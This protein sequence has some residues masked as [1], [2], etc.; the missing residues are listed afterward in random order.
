M[1]DGGLQDW[2]EAGST[3]TDRPWKEDERHATV[4]MKEPNWDA[5]AP[6]YSILFVLPLAGAVSIVALLGACRSDGDTTGRFNALEVWRLDS[7]PLMTVGDTEADPLFEVTGT[8]ITERHV[9]IA[10]EGSGTLRF[11]DHGGALET[12]VGGRGEGPGEYGDLDWMRRSGDYLFAYDR[13]GREVSRYDLD[14]RL[15]DSFSLRNEGSG[16]SAVGVFSDGSVLVEAWELHWASQPAVE[17]VPVTLHL[18]DEKGGFVRRLLEMAGPETWYE[19]VGTT[20]MRQMSRFF[21][22]ISGGA[23]VDSFFV[24]MENDSYDIPVYG[25]DGV[26]RDTMRPAV[27]PDLTPLTRSEADLSRRFLLDSWDLGTAQAEVEDMLTAMGLPEYLPPYGRLSLGYPKHPPFTVADGL[28]WALRY[29]GLPREGADPEGPEWYVF[30]PGEGQ[31]ANLASPDD[32]VLYDVL[33]DLA[34]VLR[35]T[36][37][38]EEIVELRRIVGR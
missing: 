37:L 5:R 19:P 1:D 38:D 7:V 3:S 35:R 15:L 2:S 36:E 28:V 34:A 21:G 26:V 12:E 25:P 22:R 14:G 23:V 32:V 9:V 16:V 13:Y 17:R 18:F 31:I 33:G 27:V 11:Y 30:R 8:V 6:A 24:V 10:Q 20:G 4:R 29:G